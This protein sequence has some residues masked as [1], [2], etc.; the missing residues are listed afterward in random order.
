MRLILFVLKCIVGVL[1]TIGLGLV[2]LA[3]LGVYIAGKSDAWRPSKPDMSDNMV[4]MLDLSDGLAESPDE[5]PFGRLGWGEGLLLRDAVE[6]IQAAGGDPAVKA[7]V[8]RGGRG[9]LSLTDAQELRT[10]IALFRQSGKPTFAFAETFGEGGAA[11]PHYYL[12]AA[13]GEVWTQPSATLPLL[14]FSIEQPFLRDALADLGITAQMVKREEYKSAADLL[15]EA[16]MPFP[17]RENLKR[18]IDSWM[19]VFLDDIGKDRTLAERELRA[20]ID[21]AP[22]HA[23]EALDARLVDRVGYWDEM[24]AQAD[25]AAGGTPDW[26]DLADYEVEEAKDNDEARTKIA[27]I[28]ASGPVMLGKGPSGPFEDIS[29]ASD[30]IADALSA[31]R[32]DE[33]VDAVLLRIDSPGGSYVASDVIWREVGLTREAGKPIVVSMGAVAASGGYFIAAPASKIVALPATVTG[34]IGVVTGKLVYEDLLERNDVAVEGP[35]AGAN[36]AFWSPASRFTPAQY[37]QLESL[38]DEAYRDFLQ[39]VAEGRGLALERVRAI[40]GGRVW[41]GRDA[42][43]AGLV[44]ALGGLEKAREMTLAELGLPPSHPSELLL[45]PAP[46]DP[47]EAA[48]R[49]FFGAASEAPGVLQT[50]RGLRVLVEA[51]EPAAERLRGPQGVASPQARLPAEVAAPR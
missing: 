21:R 16:G 36:A 22:L 48:M 18:L 10:A 23:G 34:S 44:D 7:L 29:L 3:G 14:G 8:I 40:A 12:A 42:L 24:T 6:R 49:E 32:E 2:L 26:I 30:D 31:A 25:L 13:A 43:D 27:L 37:A 46:G 35:R 45:Y 19:K 17:V 41:S 38:T 39:K 51:L 11:I 1:A 9:G 28:H 5:L 47:F 4:V 50:L 33:E 20:L 15:T